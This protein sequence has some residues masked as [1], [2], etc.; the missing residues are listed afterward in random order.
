[1]SSQYKNRWEYWKR[2]EF[3]KSQWFELSKH[4]NEK[5][6][7]FLSSAFSLEAAKLLGLT[8][9]PILRLD[10]PP[11]S[12]KAIKILTAD[13]EVTHLAETNAREMSELLKELL[14]EDDLLGTGYDKAKIEN[15]LMV[16]R[17]KDVYWR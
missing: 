17:S 15:L 13:N 3:T 10:L 16:S 1:M 12:T 4:A 2:M 7:I 9:V 11:N 8:S 5:N 6:L 14:V